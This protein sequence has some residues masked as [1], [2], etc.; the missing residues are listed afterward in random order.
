VAFHLV[1]GTVPQKLDELV[2]EGLIDATYLKDPWSRSYHYETTENGYV[3][4]ATDQYGKKVP[5]S[6]I[7][8]ALPRER[9]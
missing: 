3:L 9:F 1:H 7:V 8:R 2:D 4:Q 5:G 6:L